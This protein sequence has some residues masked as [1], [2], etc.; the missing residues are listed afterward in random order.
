MSVAVTRRNARELRAALARS[1]HQPHD[2]RRDEIHPWVT[3]V[4]LTCGHQFRAF[5]GEL[6]RFWSCW[7]YMRPSR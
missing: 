5:D 6:P 7:L 2:C 1:G 4:C 3:G